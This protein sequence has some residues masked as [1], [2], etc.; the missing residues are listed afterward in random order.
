MVGPNDDI[1]R[2]R[3]A[4]MRVSEL[5]RVVTV[6]RDDYVPQAIAFAEAELHARDA[7]EYPYRDAAAEEAGEP[8]PPAARWIDVYAALLVMGGASNVAMPILQGRSLE[9]IVLSVLLGAMMIPT[10]FGLRA[11]RAWAWQLNWLFMV[12]YTL[13]ACVSG[14]WPIGLV[15]FLPNAFYFARRKA[16]FH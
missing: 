10:A 16:L 9:A 6:E 11:R 14:V 4:A 15:W 13:V 7:G 12:L 8:E 1:M 5:R 3:F 2:A